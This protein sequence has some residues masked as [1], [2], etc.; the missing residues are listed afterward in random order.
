M[1]GGAAGNRCV[2]GGRDRLGAMLTTAL[3]ALSGAGC[4]C[5]RTEQVDLADAATTRRCATRAGRFR[6]ARC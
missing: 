1:A 2:R 5:D 4:D 3:T 6:P